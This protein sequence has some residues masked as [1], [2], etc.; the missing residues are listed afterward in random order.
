MK[1]YKKFYEIDNNRYSTIIA[2][3]EMFIATESFIKTGKKKLFRKEKELTTGF[4]VLKVSPAIMRLFVTLNNVELADNRK[5]RYDSDDLLI[6]KHIDN[7]KLKED[8]K[9]AYLEVYNGEIE[10][11][12]KQRDE[13]LEKGRENE[14]KICENYIKRLKNLNLMNGIDLETPVHSGCMIIKTMLREGLEHL[15]T[16]RVNAFTKNVY[17][18]EQDEFGTLTIYKLITIKNIVK[19]IDTFIYDKKLIESLLNNLYEEGR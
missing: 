13:L 3:D 10:N 11:V 15:Y 9:N 18:Y 4:K 16:E 17:L 5:Q 2:D 14:A 12:T 1:Y 8:I 6:Y 19:T 7:K